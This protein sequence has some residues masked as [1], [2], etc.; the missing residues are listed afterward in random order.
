MGELQIRLIIFINVKCSMLRSKFLLSN[1]SLP[2]AREKVESHDVQQ[3]QMVFQIQVQP[4]TTYKLSFSISQ[5]ECMDAETS[6]HIMLLVICK[7]SGSLFKKDMRKNNLL[8]PLEKL[9]V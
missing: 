2:D 5:T 4:C 9:I 3:A 1:I 8:D 6:F 7:L